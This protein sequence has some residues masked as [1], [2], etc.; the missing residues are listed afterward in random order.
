MTIVV[1]PP[2]TVDPWLQAFGQQFPSLIA[3]ERDPRC[4]VT[5]KSLRDRRA[6]GWTLE[7][8]MTTPAATVG[9]RTGAKGKLYFAFGEWKSMHA[10][11]L[12]PR[13]KVSL[14]GLRQRIE[15]GQSME[16]ALQNKPLRNPDF[17]IRHAFGKSGT[18]TDIVKMFPNV[19]YQTVLARMAN[20][21]SLEEALTMTTQQCRLSHLPKYQAFDEWKTLVD[22]AADSRCPHGAPRLIYVRMK[23][24]GMSIEEA[25]TRPKNP[26]LYFA[27]D[28]WSSLPELAADER[29][30]L[31]DK[32]SLHWRI[33]RS[34]MSVEDAVTHP[35]FEKTS[36]GEE[37]LC[38]FVRS[39]GVDVSAHDRTVAAPQEVDIYVADHRLAIEYNGVYW[40]A[41]PYRGRTYHHDKWSACRKAGVRLIQV[42]SDDYALRPEVVHSMI[43]HQL[44]MNSER[45]M[46]RNTVVSEETEKVSNMFLD[47]NHIQGGVAGSV[48]VGL[49]LKATDELVALALFK[50]GPGRR[51]E[52]TR[53]ATSVSVAGGFTKCLAYFTRSYPWTEV[54]TF[55]DLC[56]SNGGLYRAAGFVEDGLIPPDYRYVVDGVRKHKFGFRL[57][58]FRSSPDLEY[59]EG[60][61]ERELA[62]LNGLRRIWDAGKV[63]WV[64]RNQAVK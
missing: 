63:R 54:R 56:V 22:W 11:S 19:K 21:L 26:V 36:P 44:Q 41:E 53:Y 50:C 42:W 61:T 46:A 4:V 47:A 30:V 55:A 3:V 62:E 12:D 5:R 23:K 13:C 59:V 14:S 8:A 7:E 60:L 10:W 1:D 29:F 31:S 52:L 48:Y 15:N 35:R 33:H 20:G 43:R 51:W 25:I 6:K 16:E 45:V 39:L 9:S 38:G 32:S 40:H 2:T 18:L 24:Y 17:S 49:R 34:G 27:F 37:R 58:R 64:L 28:K 57:D